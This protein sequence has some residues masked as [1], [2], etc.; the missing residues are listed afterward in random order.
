MM[1]L[2]R[3]TMVQWFLFE[4]LDIDVGGDVAIIGS[5]GS[6]KSS[7]LDAVQTVLTG[8]M[9]RH[10]R[11]NASAQQ[12]TR[13]KR[14]VRSYCLGVIASGE[15]E[16]TRLRAVRNE[17]LTWL[18]LA[19]VDKASGRPV[20]VG[21]CLSA[22]VELPD[23]RF[24]G[25][26]IAVGALLGAD[27]LLDTLDGGQ[28]PRTFE[29]V[30]RCLRERA[31]VK[32]NHYGAAD[33]YVSQMIRA[34]SPPHF[35][36]DRDRFLRT[37]RKAISFRPSDST[38]EF[39]RAFVLEDSP[40]EIAELRRSIGVY[41]DIR[42]RLVELR[43]KADRLRMLNGVAQTITAAE[44]EAAVRRWELARQEWGWVRGRL[45]AGLA[46]RR[47]IEQELGLRRDAVSRHEA[48][49]D[50]LNVQI[51]NR[52]LKLFQSEP[53]Q[54]ARA[55]QAEIQMVKGEQ[56]G[57]QRD[58]EA[59]RAAVR[60]VARIALNRLGDDARGGSGSAT[61]GDDSGPR[62]RLEATG[63][64]GRGPGPAKQPPD[65]RALAPRTPDTRNNGGG[66]AGAGS[67][68]GAASG[69]G[70]VDA[71]A[72]TGQNALE[73]WLTRCR[74]ASGDLNAAH[75][76]ADPRAIDAL[77]RETG[78]LEVAADRLDARRQ[79]VQGDIAEL[80]RTLKAARTNLERVA[81]GKTLLDGAVLRLQELLADNGIVATPICDLVE[82]ADEAWRPAIEAALGAN[83]QALV[84][85]PEAAEQALALYRHAAGDLFGARI[86]NTRKSG[87]TRSIHANS[88]AHV[89][90]AGDRH[91]RAFLNYHLG[92]LIL[93]ETEAELLRED[94]ALTRDRLIS[95]GRTTT[96]LP[97]PRYLLFGRASREETRR[98]LEAELAEHTDRLFELK[99]RSAALKD[100]GDAVTRALESLR[101]AAQGRSCAE[102]RREL[103]RAGER[104]LQLEEE[105]RKVQQQR[106]PALHRELEELG[107][108]LDQ[109]RRTLAETR[110][111]IEGL[112]R[113]AG[114]T[115]RAISVLIRERRT[116]AEDR[117]SR[118]RTV[119][120]VGGLE[121]LLDRS[122]RSDPARSLEDLEGLRRDLTEIAGAHERQA[123]GACQRFERDLATYGA[124][125]SVTF[126]FEA[127]APLADKAAWIRDSLTQLDRFDLPDFEDKARQAHETFL[128]AF[129]SDF[130][131]KMTG[132]FQEISDA[133]D[134]LNKALRKRDFHGE[135]YAF[136]K[137]PA[138][139]FS[140]L[141]QLIERAREPDF[142]LPLFAPPERDEPLA[143]A[144]AL[145][146]EIVAGTGDVREFEDPR[147]YFEFELYIYD[148]AGELKSSLA[149]RA[150]TGSGGEY[151]IPLYVSM[152][153]A[154]AATYQDRM[155]GETGMALAV[156]DEAFNRLDVR[157]LQQCAGFL[158]DVGLQTVL[159]APDEK[160]AVFLAE[161]DCLVNLVRIG[162][163]VDIHVEWPRERA[164]E[165]LRS[166][167]PRRKGVEG[168]RAE[169]V[170]RKA[171]SRG[172]PS[173]AAAVTN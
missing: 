15:E 72:K 97:A 35:P 45:R 16:G 62:L 147:N 143:R 161:V 156:F 4:A 34:L 100:A 105:L 47:R 81:A 124:E 170:A 76:P 122:R 150:A 3:I 151:Q 68:A 39:V 116:W 24:E 166:E 44:R 50:G 154:L 94:S 63:Q 103:V 19:F 82:Q 14:T 90:T 133:L 1:E 8:G 172:R 157:N 31:A 13:S 36:I 6:G 155:R 86:V 17:A 93:V 158:R 23:E 38:S 136:R 7:I 129:K 139:K 159:A 95:R 131:G 107:R 5:N 32:L 169:P 118:L 21:V 89:I 46:D 145:V 18:T 108:R 71:A 52:R 109:E 53:E 160:H 58:L 9:R 111:Q 144:T 20:T 25:G 142:D 162:E 137:A 123:Q 134:E 40:V 119:R 87:Y 12:E 11:Y 141:I 64:D 28:V 73:A 152:A 69:A 106:D 171:P 165:T 99:K 30:M 115:E 126:P 59:W 49:V 66:D 80:E 65:S 163:H 112:S 77:A 51:E 96:R 173:K 102:A 168:F 114:D 113:Q 48:T 43:C 140:D 88:A 138:R 54:R 120:A 79:V 104:L 98:R 60:D 83:V 56:H 101:R 153:A 75:W 29:D 110:A 135:R 91:A 128:H 22:S 127:A 33:R 132:K 121:R 146:E 61:G 55:I 2:R 57:L 41:K 149:Q 74:A 85:A 26:F 67:G 78:P 70:A 92:H 84:V 167:D 42:A 130:V 37:F 125:F 148:E 27:E 117:R 10:L 164:R